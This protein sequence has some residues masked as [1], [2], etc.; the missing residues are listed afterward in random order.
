MVM[1]VSSIDLKAIVVL[2]KA[3][4]IF[5][6]MESPQIE[7]SEKFQA[8]YRK[9]KDVLDNFD[10]PQPSSSRRSE[11]AT[12][13][14]DTIVFIDTTGFGHRELDRSQVIDDSDMSVEGKVRG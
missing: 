11:S 8:I 13:K 3:D 14:S 6:T 7:R 1:K 9:L 12:G 10:M 4:F 5:Q 2:D